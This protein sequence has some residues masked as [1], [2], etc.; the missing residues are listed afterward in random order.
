[1][2]MDRNGFSELDRL[3]SSELGRCFGSEQCRCPRLVEEFGGITTYVKRK[4]SQFRLVNLS[5]YVLL[6]GT[7][8]VM[9]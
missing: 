9:S 1:M 4:L 7:R 8:V 6:L 3:S 5:Q 2:D